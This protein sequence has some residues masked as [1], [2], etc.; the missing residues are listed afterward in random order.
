MIQRSGSDEVLRW[1]SSSEILR[2]LSDFNHRTFFSIFFGHFRW[3]S[4]FNR[5]FFRR[6]FWEM[7]LVCDEK[8]E[9]PPEIEP[10]VRRQSEIKN[11]KIHVT[12]ELSFSLK[13]SSIND[14]TQ[15]WTIFDP[16]LT[17]FYV[18]KSSPPPAPLLPFVNKNIVLHFKR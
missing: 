8:C 5:S 11:L 14:V 15:I 1:C 7:E 16:F 10:K 12:M 13:W 3:F 17:L 2:A 9:F 6:Q 4:D 18:T